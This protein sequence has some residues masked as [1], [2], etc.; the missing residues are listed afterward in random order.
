MR[1]ERLKPKFDREYQARRGSVWFYEPRLAR[2][3]ITVA[4]GPESQFLNLG[5]RLVR[6]ITEETC[7]KTD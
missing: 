7:S 5:F 3:V 1:Q 4:Y 2:E 6:V